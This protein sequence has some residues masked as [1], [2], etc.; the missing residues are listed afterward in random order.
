[1]HFST[2]ALAT[3][4]TTTATATA[5]TLLQPTEE[6]GDIFGYRMHAASAMI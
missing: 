1:V 3:A 5:S 6:F 2:G 4:T